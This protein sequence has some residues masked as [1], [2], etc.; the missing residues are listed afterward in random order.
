MRQVRVVTDSLEVRSVLSRNV[1]FDH[2]VLF[3]VASAFPR[4]RSR[5]GQYRSR[6]RLPPMDI[7]GSAVRTQMEQI[8]ARRGISLFSDS[9]RA[10]LEAVTRL[11]TPEE[12][13][14]LGSEGANPDQSAAQ[15]QAAVSVASPEELAVLSSAPTVNY[16]GMSF[17]HVV[18]PGDIPL[19]DTP[20]AEIPPLT[21]AA[22]A[23]LD[24]IYEQQSDASEDSVG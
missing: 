8:L 2:P 4:F 5:F 20:A 19:S 13:D 12:V 23:E 21:P 1:G 6:F 10:E 11:F 24:A 3:D 9:A 16:L 18:L 15:D 14:S 7:V 22:I 17:Q